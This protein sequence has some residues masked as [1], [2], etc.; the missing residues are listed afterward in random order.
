MTSLTQHI[1]AVVKDDVRL[2]LSP[3]V[4]LINCIKQELKRP[5]AR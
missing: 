4:A 2:F 5:P 1:K 3:F